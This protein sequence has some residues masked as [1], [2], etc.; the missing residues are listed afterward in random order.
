MS[1]LTLAAWVLNRVQSEG[2]IGLLKD[3]HHCEYGIVKL[4]SQ[5]SLPVDD[6][7]R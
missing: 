6:M 4:I 1:S 3:C 7:G 2:N 5:T